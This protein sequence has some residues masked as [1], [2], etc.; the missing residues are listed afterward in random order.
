V[1]NPRRAL[2]TV[3]DVERG[4]AGLEPPHPRNAIAS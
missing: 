2:R 4:E 3:S 1:K